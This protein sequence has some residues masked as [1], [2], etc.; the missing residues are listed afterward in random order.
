MHLTPLLGEEVYLNHKIG[1]YDQYVNNISVVILFYERMLLGMLQERVL[2]LEAHIHV[3]A[4]T[5]MAR[6]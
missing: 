6:M 1:M 4:H 3:C 5:Y 2:F